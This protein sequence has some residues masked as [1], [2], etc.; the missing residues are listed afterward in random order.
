ML[1]LRTKV[2]FN[3]ITFQTDRF[4]L[5]WRLVESGRNKIL[6]KQIF[7]ASHLHHTLGMTKSL[8]TRS[9]SEQTPVVRTCG[10]PSSCMPRLTHQDTHYLSEGN[11]LWLR[12]L[13]RNMNNLIANVTVFMLW[14]IVLV[15]YMKGINVM[16]M[17]VISCGILA[18]KLQDASRRRF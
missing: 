6:I 5:G 10:R 9:P 4:I 14:S 1:P 8:P 17:N 7:R 15:Y 2:R 3:Q 18:P 16:T 13:V 11:H 12:H